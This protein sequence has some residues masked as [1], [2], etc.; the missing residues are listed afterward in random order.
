MSKQV[1]YYWKNNMKH[2]WFYHTV[3][4]V[5]SAN[6]EVSTRESRKTKFKIH[7]SQRRKE[8]RKRNIFMTYSDHF[9]NITFAYC[10][11]KKFLYCL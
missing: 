3:Q 4:G 2:S 5:I 7:S 10:V 9:F 6:A 11:N 1:S 8:K